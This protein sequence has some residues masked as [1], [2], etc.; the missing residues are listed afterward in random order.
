KWYL[1]IRN[2]P[3][4]WENHKKKVRAYMKMKRRDPEFV[5]KEKERKRIYYLTRVKGNAEKYGEIKKKSRERGRIN[6]Q[7]LKKDK[8]KHEE[9][10]R[11]KRE[12]YK[13]KKADA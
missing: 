7:R 9:Y 8:E 11:R 12:Y 2:D 6:Y 4:R 5:K 10:L 1:K 3:N 13:K